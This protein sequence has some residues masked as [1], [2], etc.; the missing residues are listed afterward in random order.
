MK[1]LKQ[2]IRDFILR[3]TDVLASEITDCVSGERLGRGLVVG[4][5]GKVAVI[6]YSGRPL[7]PCFLPQARLTYWKQEIGFTSQPAPDFPRC[8][9]EVPRTDVPG[10]AR[11]LN[12]IIAHQGG[13]AFERLLDRWSSVCPATD[14]WIA[15]GGRLE[16]FN[17]LAYPRKIFIHEM[18]LRTRDHQREKQSYTPIMR[19]F[20]PVVEKER[21]DFVY[22]C[23][24][25]QI[26]LERDL[27]VRQ[28]EA[29]RRED[30]DMMGH[31]LV[32]MDGTGHPH[33]L[34]HKADP[35]FARF[36]GSISRRD[37]PGV[38]LSMFGSGSFWTREAFL[39]VASVD[40]QIPCY[41]EIYLPT[42]AHHLG[43]RVRG[44][45]E[46][47]HLISNHPSPKITEEEA[48]KRG[49]L[50]VHPIKEI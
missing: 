17:E 14:L 21:P 33:L 42:L 50:T 40:Q 6:G 24:Y 34:N 47:Q 35:E 39:A 18:G 11:V 7:T 29:I 8:G 32:R 16:D 12:L 5:G 19:A 4:L 10:G 43:Y 23:E 3:L 41:L 28:V 9:I 26:P 25:D 44:W 37:D 31:Y 20:K 1:P 27:N 15:F 48:R 45:D 30:A 38:I 46:S 2:S 36:W 49:C 13:A 22:F